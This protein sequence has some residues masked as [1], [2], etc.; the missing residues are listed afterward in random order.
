MSTKL[1]SFATTHYILLARSFVFILGCIAV[2]W[3]IV[4]FPVFWRESSA[5]SIADRI[6]AGDPFRVELLG[7]QLPMINSIET[8]AYCRPAALRSAAIVRLRIADEALSTGAQEATNGRMVTLSNSLHESLSCSPADPYLWL[9]LS[10]ME[11][12]R[13]GFNPAAL[14][15]LSI[16]YQLGP[17]EGW[18]GLKRNR[19][20]F[21]EFEKLSAALAERTIN[22]FIALLESGFYE[23]GAEILIGPAWRV[24]E[25][26]LPRLQNIDERNRRAFAY[27]LYTKGY[28]V[29]VP[30]VERPAL[31]PWR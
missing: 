5:E 17:N 20:A 22:E 29:E 12:N 21:S 18:I 4:E 16:S 1:T 24:R 30:G 25:Q 15:Y 8:S 19:L 9:A 3:G 23:D 26:L 31:R 6:I 13:N 14:K 7:R 27:L 10:W 11:T 28:D 2:W